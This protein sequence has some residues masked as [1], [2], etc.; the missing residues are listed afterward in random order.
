[1]HVN[2]YSLEAGISQ[3][4]PTYATSVIESSSGVQEAFGIAGIHFLWVA[5]PLF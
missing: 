2:S 5:A 3:R 4:G 1:M